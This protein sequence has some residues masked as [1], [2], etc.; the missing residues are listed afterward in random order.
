MTWF[1]NVNES[2]VTDELQDY[3]KDYEFQDR[4]IYQSVLRIWA[5]NGTM[6]TVFQLN[7]ETIIENVTHAVNGT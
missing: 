1:P 4:C 6:D 7:Q 3:M 5:S 2:E